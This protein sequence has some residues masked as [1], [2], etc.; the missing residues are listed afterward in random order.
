M[1]TALRTFRMSLEIESIWNAT[2]RQEGSLKIQQIFIKS[3]KRISRHFPTFCSARWLPKNRAANTIP[4]SPYTTPRCNSRTL[5]VLTQ[6]Y[7]SPSR[8]EIGGPPSSILVRSPPVDCS[9]RKRNE[10]NPGKVGKKRRRRRRRRE[11]KSRN[12]HAI[13]SQW[14]REGKKQAFVVSGGW[15]GSTILTSLPAPR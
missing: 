10:N 11:E 7:P 1:S 3:R 4:S 6:I 8:T 12:E 9:S 13:V 2:A 5:L 15:C 14:R